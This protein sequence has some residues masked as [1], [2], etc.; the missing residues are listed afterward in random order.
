MSIGDELR[1]LG[2]TFGYEHGN[3]EERIE[4]WVNEKAGTA[5]RIEWMKVDREV[6]GRDF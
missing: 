3:S 1:E 5:V 6:K 2:Y 4:V